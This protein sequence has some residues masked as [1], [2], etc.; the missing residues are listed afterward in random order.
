VLLDEAGDGGSIYRDGVALEAGRVIYARFIGER[1]I[2][3]VIK[4]TNS[5][6]IAQ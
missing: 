2:P 5:V 6:N 1:V 3:D 4:Q